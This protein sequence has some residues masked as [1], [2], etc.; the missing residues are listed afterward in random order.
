MKKSLPRRHLFVRAFLL[1]VVLVTAGSMTGFV[2][3]KR[4]VKAAAPGSSTPTIPGIHFVD[5]SQS[6]GL[7]F[8]HNNGAFGQKFLPETLGP[9]CAFV[10]FDNDGYPDILLVNGQ[11][12]PGHE[13]SGK[14][15]LK[16]YH[17]NHD[18]SF[19]DVT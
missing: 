15:T 12:W 19:T 16:L 6:A 14:S 5:I 18:G 10:D 9:G 2:S 4:I 7:R 3:K 13:S 17:N 8:T 11:S 1:L